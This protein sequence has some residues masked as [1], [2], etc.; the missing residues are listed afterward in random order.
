MSRTRHSAASSAGLQRRRERSRETRLLELTGRH[1][2]A[3]REPV[4]PAVLLPAPGLRTRRPDHPVTD[5][6]D[7]AALLGDGDEVG[8]GEQPAA[9]MVPAQQ[10]LDS[11]DLAGGQG[12]DRLVVQ[13]EL[14]PVQGAAQ[15]GLQLEPF[16]EC[17]VHRGL[18]RRVAAVAVPLRAVHGDVGVAQQFVGRDTAEFALRDADAGVDGDFQPA[19]QEGPAH[20]GD[21]AVG[22][23]P[24]P[25]D[26]GVVEE[27]HE[28]VAPE[29]R[30]GVAHAQAS[31]QPVRDLRQQDVARRV[32][33]RVVDHLEPVEVDEEKGEVGSRARRLGE[34]VFQAVHEQGAACQA[35]E[36]I[37]EGAV[38]GLEGVRVRHGEAHVFGEREERRLL[39]RRELAPRL[40]R[41]RDQP[42][43]HP[44]TFVHGSSD[45]DAG[46]DM[47]RNVVSGE[48]VGV[49]RLG[50]QHRL[51]VPDGVRHRKGAQPLSELVGAARARSDFDPGIGG[52][53]Q[54]DCIDAEQRPGA[55]RDGVEDAGERLAPR[56][57]LLD[58]GQLLQQPLPFPQRR[59]QLSVLLGLPLALGPQPSF[60]FQRVHHVEDELDRAGHAPEET[61]LGGAERSSAGRDEVAVQSTFDGHADGVRTVS[62]CDPRPGRR[63]C[64]GQAQR[65]LA[66]MGDREQGVARD[67]VGRVADLGPNSI[68]RHDRHDRRVQGQRGPRNGGVENRALDGGA[69][70]GGS[71]RKR[72]HGG[73]E[74]RQQLGR[75]H[76]ER[77]TGGVLAALLAADSVHNGSSASPRWNEGG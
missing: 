22:D 72:R 2:D 16:E 49:Y 56:D 33:E 62:R 11:G 12:D 8:R 29:P 5:R 48:L 59:E 26:V 65:Q 39:C 31:A 18:I 55:A 67:R 50:G 76:R 3:D 27:H 52:A 9:R 70:F 17:G 66:A 34:A 42:A 23:D 15:L 68:V 35:G 45:R 54:D 64:G 69:R 28:L 4:S 41:R 13:D 57:H 43:A 40:V 71:A 44:G 14:G 24:G 1:V 6:H 10:G 36:R 63:T 73:E 75:L 47:G 32:T 21:D 38:H 46:R 7:L 61:D 53:A 58:Q 25:G 37:V 51:P 19:E 30:G 20:G 74:L 60:G 77:R